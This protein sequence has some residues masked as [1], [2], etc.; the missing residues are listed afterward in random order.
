MERKGETG[1]CEAGFADFM[2]FSVDC[3]KDEFYW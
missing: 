2:S 3:S 1:H